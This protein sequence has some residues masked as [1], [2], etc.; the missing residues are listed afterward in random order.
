[1]Y[2]AIDRKPENGGEIQNSACGWSTIMMRLK[3]VKTAEEE[4][5]HTIMDE[6]LGML[7][8][9]KVLISLVQPWLG[10]VHTVCGDSYFASVGAATK[11]EKRGMGFLGVV[12]T[13]TRHFPMAYM[14]NI[15]MQSRGEREGVVCRDKHGV[16]KLMA[17]VWMDRDR[18]YFIASLSSLR[19]GT[20]YVRDRWRQVDTSPD[21]DAERV[22]LTVDQ[23]EACQH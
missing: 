17:F 11:M 18:R 21:A 15:E 8:G 9:T 22:E 19:K 20:G 3:I 5:M 7:H 23:P 2:V 16:P 13:A 10:S 4:A 12:K 1:M 14:T 6:H